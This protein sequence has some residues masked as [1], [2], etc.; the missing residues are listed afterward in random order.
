MSQA[1]RLQLV[2]DYMQTI[3]LAAGN[4]E[5]LEF[6]ANRNTG[7]GAPLYLLD[8]MPVGELHQ[9]FTDWITEHDA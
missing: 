3:R 6:L 9:L 5:F 4:D 1:R 7:E 2:K 8:N